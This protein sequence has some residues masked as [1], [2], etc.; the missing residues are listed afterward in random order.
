MISASLHFTIYFHSFP[1][2]HRYSTSMVAWSP[3]GEVLASASAEAREVEKK[4]TGKE[5][6]SI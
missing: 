4:A 6:K 5:E 2:G 3:S 1:G